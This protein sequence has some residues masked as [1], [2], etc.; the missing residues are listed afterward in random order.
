MFL[1]VQPTPLPHLSFA[2]FSCD[3]LHTSLFE[4]VSHFI[5]T[6]HENYISKKMPRRIILIR[7]GE[8]EGNVDPQ[9]YN[10]VPDNKLKLTKNGEDQATS[11]GVKLQRII[12]NESVKFIISP[13][14][15]TI[16][17]Y[18]NISK[19]KYISKTH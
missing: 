17:T 18:E 13:Y 12:K 9:L 4:R 16:Q 6:H 19:A 5:Q 14:L 7:H 1:N 8:S 2:R 11:A 15:R 3:S 10:K